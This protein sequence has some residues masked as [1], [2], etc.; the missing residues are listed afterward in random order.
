MFGSNKEHYSFSFNCFK[1]QH[2]IATQWLLKKKK[3]TTCTHYSSLVKF[4]VCVYLAIIMLNEIERD[5]GTS[6]RFPMKIASQDIHPI[7]YSSKKILNPAFLC[8]VHLWKVSRLTGHCRSPQCFWDCTCR[9]IS[10]PPPCDVEK[11][12]IANSAKY[13]LVVVG[14]NQYNDHCFV[15]ASKRLLG[16]LF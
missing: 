7:M 2:C 15:Y 1:Q 9:R 12:F 4:T 13:I 6:V 10:L 3:E 5:L 14:S 8:A 11:R 16:R